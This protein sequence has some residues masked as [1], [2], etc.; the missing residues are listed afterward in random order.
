MQDGNRRQGRLPQREDRNSR[1]LRQERGSGSGLSAGS[2]RH[3]EW[4]ERFHEAIRE[5]LVRRHT[6]R[7][8][9]IA[10]ITLEERNPIIDAI[11]RQCPHSSSIQNT[12]CYINEGTVR[13]LADSSHAVLRE[14]G[15]KCHHFYTTNQLVQY[16]EPSTGIVLAPQQGEASARGRWNIVSKCWE[17]NLPGEVESSVVV[18]QG[19]VS[20][21]RFVENPPSQMHLISPMHV[22]ALLGDSALMKYLLDRG[23]SVQDDN[24]AE[25]ISPLHL[26]I[27]YDQIQCIDLLRQ[28]G[29]INEE[30]I[31]FAV[32][33]GSFACILAMV[34]DN[35]ETITDNVLY[36]V[37]KRAEDMYNFLKSERGMPVHE[38][39]EYKAL[40]RLLADPASTKES[41]VTLIGDHPKAIQYK[42]GRWGDGSPLLH[43]LITT[44]SEKFKPLME[45][46]REVECKIGSIFDT[47]EKNKQGKTIL[48]LALD[49]EDKEQIAQIL[50]SCIPEINDVQQ[51]RILK[52]QIDIPKIYRQEK[53]ELRER[54]VQ[55]HQRS[56]EH[57]RITQ[58]TIAALLQTREE[59][60]ELR[61]E[62]AELRVFMQQMFLAMG[63]GS[64]HQ[65]N[66]QRPVFPQ[67]GE[68]SQPNNPVPQ[69]LQHQA[70]NPNQ[71]LSLRNREMPM[72]EEFKQ[73]E[74]P[75]R[76]PAGAAAQPARQQPIMQNGRR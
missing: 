37:E 75:V 68:R 12:L 64:P 8:V 20:T 52:A 16:V 58:E 34:K 56:S 1:E 31:L 60:A 4:C 55:L 40:E 18:Y 33:E 29:H 39:P 74:Q 35:P 57:E 69:R 66:A 19:D 36:A 44:K 46:I 67:E 38:R 9:P 61:R 51:G 5:D 70:G 47:E 43:H 2:I 10:R 73:V 59:V 28:R 17:L 7:S 14:W 62:N 48:D 32:K 41:L 24:N 50:S 26:V 76:Q 30:A 49:Q 27:M 23:A 25:R 53:K 3:R 22:A 15:Q 45:A 42:Q 72:P 21:V 11:K 71:F 54:L 65:G 63:M 6:G 13:L